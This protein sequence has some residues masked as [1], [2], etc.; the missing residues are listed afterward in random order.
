MGAQALKAAQV[1]LLRVVVVGSVDDGKSTLIGR[2][3]YEA[4]ALPDD[5]VKA[6][7][8]ASKTGGALDFSLFTDGLK[9]EREQGI[10]ID[11]AYRHFA[12]AKRRFIVADTPGHV[13]YTRNMATGASTAEVGIIL[14]D[15]RLGVLP[16]TR[17]HASIASLLGIPHLAVVINKMDLAGYDQAVFRRIETE[18]RALTAK[19]GF[20]QV[21]FFPVS[22]TQGDN[23]VEPSPKTPWHQGPPLLQF[24]ETVQ[25]KRWQDTAP[26]RLPVQLAIRDGQDWRGYAGQIASGEVTVGQTVVVAP[27][28]RT[29][30]V[31]EIRGPTGPVQ[32]AQA[33]SSVAIVLADQVDASRGEMLVTQGAVPQAARTLDAVLV[34]LDEAPLEPSREY[35]V[36]HTTRSA[37]ARVTAV[38][39]KTDHETWSQVPAQTLGLNDI[40]QVQL[41]VP[42]GLLAE[43]YA[44]NRATGALIVIDPLSRA[45]VAAGMVVSVVAGGAEGSDG[46]PSADERRARLGHRGLAIAVPQAH[47]EWLERALF[48]RGLNAVL[49]A[50]EVQAAACAAGGL[51]ALFPAPGTETAEAALAR[52]L[53]AL[54]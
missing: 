22:A 7:Q 46:R 11:V 10:T 20:Q 38:R 34:W 45:T 32:R 44:Q 23:V 53:A 48:D 3:L 42:R 26:F 40:G 21:S 25:V 37:P 35:L 33:P 41:N 16:Q 5:V 49:V 39:W 29:S 36:K 19:L 50:N 43:P 52:V 9:A 15:A 17:R 4:H 27:S 2:L 47:G 14:I 12:T 6:V 8:R 13:Q 51:V 28:G 30:T 24:L 54:G 18:V 1:D 31:K